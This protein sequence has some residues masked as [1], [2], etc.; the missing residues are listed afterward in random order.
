VAA[1]FNKLLARMQ[2]PER[3]VDPESEQFDRDV[4]AHQVRTLLASTGLPARYDADAFALRLG[5]GATS[6]LGNRFDEYARAPAEE[7]DEVVLHA[8]RTIVEASRAEPLADDLGDVGPYLR[9]RVRQRA[10][11]VI[12]RLH[13]DA[14]QLPEGEAE[15]RMPVLLPLTAD[16]GAEV[17]YDTPTSIVTVPSERVGVWGLTPRRALKMA[18]ENLLDCA[19]EPFTEVAPGV[20]RASVGDC[21]DSARLLLTKVV[22]ALPLHGDPVALPANRDTLV[23]TGSE[24]LTGLYHLLEAALE[25]MERPRVDTLQ[26]VVLRGG[27]WRDWLPPREHTLHEAFY[28]LATR[29]RGTSYA[30]VKALLDA[31][32][33]EKGDDLFVAAY[34]LLRLAAGSTLWSHAV[35]GPVRGWLPE[36]DLVSVTSPDAESYVVV[37]R[38]PLLKIGGHLLE[39]VPGM[40]PPYFA[41][42]GA[43][44]RSLYERLRAHAVLEGNTRG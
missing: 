1:F 10:H 27:R 40:D 19:P 32:L 20:Y 2:P 22:A 7:R 44:D 9:P 12:Q 21:Y 43:P 23:I 31:R 11:L 28:E 17:V 38:A 6:W 5:A 16:L 42:D 29:T 15:R 41:F 39:R 37:P 25:V 30:E 36:T 4:F 33:E 35:W 13:L 34:G 26:P 18:T 8:V 24:H 14:E 3:D